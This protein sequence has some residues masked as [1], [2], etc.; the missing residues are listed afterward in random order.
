MPSKFHAISKF[1]I[2]FSTYILFTYS[3]IYIYIYIYIYTYIFMYILD[4]LYIY[5]YIS[6]NLSVMEVQLPTMSCV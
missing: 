6:G 5:I 1:I 4:I 3:Y 2:T